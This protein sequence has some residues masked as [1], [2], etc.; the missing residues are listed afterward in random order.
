MPGAVRPVHPHNHGRIIGRVPATA[1][2]A[3]MMLTRMKRLTIEGTCGCWTDCPGEL[4]LRGRLKV[5]PN[6]V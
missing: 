6:R 4:V 3:S 5:S 1:S 2:H